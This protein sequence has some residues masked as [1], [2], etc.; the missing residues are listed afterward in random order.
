VRYTGSGEHKRFPN[1]LC[2]PALRTDASDCDSV[3]PTVSQDLPRLQRWL[4]AAL[5]AG[6]VDR[7][8]EGGFPRKAWGWIELGEPARRLLFEARLTNSGLGEYKGYFIELDDLGGKTA[9]VHAMLAPGGA[10]S[11]VLG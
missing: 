2:P 8:L 3:D 9:W 6:Q 7:V 1:P 11:E 5:Q 4:E 10:W